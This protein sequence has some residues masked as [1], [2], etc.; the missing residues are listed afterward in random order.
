[1]AWQTIDYVYPIAYTF[2]KE[3]LWLASDAHVYFAFRLH[4]SDNWTYFSG[5]ASHALDAGQKLTEYATEADAQTNYLQTAKDANGK[6]LAI[7]TRLM[8]AKYARLCVETGS[9]V[10][11]KEW[12]P[13]VYLSAHEIIGGTLEI[14]DQL[15]DTPSI[16]VTANS[17]ERL[18]MGELS[19][20]IFGL[21][22][23]DSNGNVIF[24]INTNED[25]PFMEGYA[26]HKAIELELMKINFQ[27]ISWA[28]FAIFDS[29]D[30]ETKRAD[31]DPSANAARVY[32]SKLDN[33][34]DDTTSREFGFVSK[35]YT[36]I[37]TVDSGTSTSVGTNF[38]A[39]TAQ[40]WFADE[41]KNLTL[42]DSED[43]EFTVTSN[44]SDT[45]TVSGTPAAGAYTLKDANPSYAVAFASYLDSTNGGAGYTKLEISFDGG[46]N[47]Q[48]FLDTENSV[49]LLQG[50]VAIANSGHD[51][52][53]RI[54]LKNDVSGVGSVLYKFL[55]CT[56]PSPWR[57]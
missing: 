19:T 32:K 4:E 1:M 48:T 9:G 10:W 52:I 7:L 33:G 51:Y 57:Y 36:G 27:S 53:A 26:D 16:K 46:S 38:L 18:L 13:S 54:T 5:N 8:Q 40:S 24:E 31:P 47:W 29:L 43:S 12:R 55:V 20:N 11:L 2:H 6:V 15:S 42:V 39:D 21:R 25:S 17:L 14:T 37:T 3:L 35:T 30:D 56:D 45:L 34:D 28:Q 23:K 50:T 44:T 22:G 41:C 49:N